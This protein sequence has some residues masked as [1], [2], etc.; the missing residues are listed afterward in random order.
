PLGVSPTGELM[1][2]D[3]RIAINDKALRRHQDLIKLTSTMA[4]SESRNQTPINR[5]KS[6]FNRTNPTLT[7]L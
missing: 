3:G 4:E 1:A 2:L 5:D 7:F 6:V